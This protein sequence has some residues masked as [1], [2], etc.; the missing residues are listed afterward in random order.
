MTVWWPPMQQLLLSALVA[1]VASRAT[2][3]A[4]ST[5]PIQLAGLVLQTEEVDQ[6][7]PLDKHEHLVAVQKD[8]IE[9]ENL[10]PSSSPPKT[11]TV[12]AQPDQRLLL[13]NVP[14]LLVMLRTEDD[15]SQLKL[16]AFDAGGEHL[17]LDA[18]KTFANC[19]V[20][21]LA[22]QR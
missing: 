20:K 15:R 9:W 4:A 18:T 10:I 8:L 3:P 6:Q 22:N 12:G 14:Y 1:V 11:G 19:Q 13:A 17:L 16:F 21:L 2:N 7:L 5:A